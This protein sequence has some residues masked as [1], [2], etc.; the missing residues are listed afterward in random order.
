LFHSRGKEHPFQNAFFG[1][2]LDT[3]MDGMPGAEGRGERSPFTTILT[4]MNDG[5]EEAVIVDGNISP[6]R[7]EMPDYFFPLFSGIISWPE[8]IIFY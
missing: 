4:D 7:G 3:D 2:A 8:Y 6:P 1:P 5:I